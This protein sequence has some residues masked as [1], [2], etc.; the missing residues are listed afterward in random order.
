MS[1][2]NLEEIRKRFGSGQIKQQHLE[3]IV[4]KEIYGEN[5]ER[6]RE[7]CRDAALIRCEAIEEKTGAS[8]ECIKKTDVD[9]CNLLEDGEILSGIEMKVGAAR[10]PLGI[11]GPLA[12]PTQ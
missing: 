3:T 5:S 11:A 7:A 12:V 8:L 4:F 6:I 9:N 1:K 10:I 2:G